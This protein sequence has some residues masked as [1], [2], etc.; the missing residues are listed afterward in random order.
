MTNA[1]VEAAARADF[2]LSRGLAADDSS[3]DEISGPTR[4]QAL[5]RAETLL[6]AIDAADD[7]V[8]LTL[9]EFHAIRADTARDLSMSLHSSWDADQRAA[10]QA[11]GVPEFIQD[12]TAKFEDH[13]VEPANHEA[14]MASLIRER[15]AAALRT[16]ADHF[17]HASLS[18]IAAD[19]DL[20]PGVSPRFKRIMIRGCAE[21]LRTRADELNEGSRTPY[22]RVNTRAVID[23]DCHA[24]LLRALAEVINRS[25]RLA[26]IGKIESSFIMTDRLIDAIE[27]AGATIPTES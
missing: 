27:G 15:L 21:W 12:Y 9:P 5:A 2:N 16:T 11:A 1:R 25:F 22:Y 18:D 10:A 26:S 24:A 8:R 14:A 20:D 19:M 7:R 4:D 13:Y 6:A 3:W 17:D 23:E